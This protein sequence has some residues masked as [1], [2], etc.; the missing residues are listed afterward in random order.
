MRLGC[1]SV[2]RPGLS[3]FGILLFFIGAADVAA[4]ATSVS[5]TGT[6]ATTATVGTAYQFKPTATSTRNRRLYFWVSNKPSWTKFDYRSGAL[7]GTPAASAVGT[8]KNIVVWATDGRGYAS[9]PAFAI[10]VSAGTSTPSPTNRPPTISGTPATSVA[11]GKAYS[12]TPTA[13]D[14]D[15]GSLFFSIENKPTWASFSISNGALT[16]TPT[17]TGTHPD[18]KISVSDGKLSA[19]LSAFTLTV[20]AASTPTDA[21]APSV[22]GGVKA[23]ATSGSQVSVS[24]TASTDNVGVT[25]YRVLR[26]GTQVGT[27]STT[28]YADSGLTAGKTYSYRVTAVDAA[29]NVS[30]QSAAASVTTPAVTTPPPTS[31]GSNFA[32]RCAA[33]GVIKCV[34]FDQASD[35]AGQYGNPSGTTPGTASK[36]A[37]DTNV[38]ASGGSSLKFT[39]PTNSGSDAAGAYFTNFANDLSVQFGENSEFYVQWRQRFS[40]EFLNTHF[41]NGDGWKQV[42][43]GTGDQPAQLYA[44]CTS[45]EVVVNNYSDAPTQLPIMYNSCSGST[46]HGPYDGFYQPFNGTDFKLQNARPAPYCLY[47]QGKT[48]PKTF[49]PPSGN[50]FGYFPNEWM[51]YQIR[52]KTGPRVNDEFTNS[53]VSLWIGR[54]GKPSEP[55]IEWGPYNLTAGSTTLN[56][57]FGKVWL[58]P[59]NTVKSSSQAHPTAYTWYDELIISRTKIADP[60]T[61]G[62]GT[63]PPP[64]PAPTDTTAPSVPTGLAATPASTQVSLAWNASTDD[65]GVAGYRVRRNGTQIATPVTRSFVDTG[66]TTATTYTYTVAAVDAAGNVSNQSPGVS[67]TTPQATTPPPP[68]NTPPPTSGTSLASLATNLKVGQWAELT[69]GG[70][71]G[72]YLETAPGASILHYADKGV[73][74]PVRRKFYFMGAPHAKPD[75]FI[76]YNE[77]SAT[78]TTGP[79]PCQFASSSSCYVTHGYEHLTINPATGELYYRTYNST[80]LYKYSPNSNTWSELPPVP[81]T[82]KQCCGG[83]EWFPDRNELVFVDGDWGVWTYSPASNAWTRRAD[84]N[85]KSGASSLSLPMASYSNIAQYSPK[86][87]AVLFGGGRKLYKYS[88][89]GTLTPVADPPLSVQVADSVI[90]PD[91]ASGNFLVHG[92]GNVF[93]EFNMAANTWTQRSASSVPPL[94]KNSSV[95]DSIAAPISNHGVVMYIKYDFG[96]SKVYIYKHAAR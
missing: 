88:A 76:I 18:V 13:S 86:D 9:L 79:S 96:N 22:P 81:T 47:T 78:W 48:S 12:F 68:T 30:A 39:I 67:A 15:G 87:K 44:S 51:T 7:S 35:I 70:F 95:F 46:S 17:S 55:V 59:Y 24:W 3:F 82:V 80:Q 52:I 91:P 11:V 31:G 23:T 38:S 54:E 28:S 57:R 56:Q 71:S 60:G 41:L 83:V 8:Y 65:T 58:T 1:R 49:M 90:V 89:S 14:P 64:A 43:I 5:I 92:N 40:P 10:A 20:T 25:G 74:D 4:A 34:G 69:G 85:G 73:W 27:A 19:A 50:C 75:K 53:Y 32:T 77:A 66:L 84:T 45:L 42:I 2:H 61:D 72:S 94:W 6:P 93:Y 33:A 63:T 37:L 16:G 21:T 36:P 62:G 29:G 26:D